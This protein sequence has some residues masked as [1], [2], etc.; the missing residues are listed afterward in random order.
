[1]LMCFSLFALAQ[2]DQTKGIIQI[3]KR[4]IV[5]D[6]NTTVGA[7]GGI[8]IGGNGTSFLLS[9]SEGSTI[10]NIGAEVGYFALDN[11]AIKFGLGY[12]IFDDFRLFSYKLGLKYYIV[13]RVPF[14]I[15]FSGQSSEDFFGDENPSY[16]GLQA[17]FAFFIGNMVSLEPSLRY[18]ISLGDDYFENIF[19]VQIGFSIFF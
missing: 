2:E 8:I 10:W 5:I 1:M 12:G 19:Q 4:R 7:I 16:L 14:Q 6:A 13:S 17:G 9:K 15:D 18:N 3:T 11:L